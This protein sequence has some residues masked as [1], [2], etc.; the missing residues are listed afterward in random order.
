MYIYYSRGTQ[1]SQLFQLQLHNEVTRE[2]ATGKQLLQYT[3]KYVEG[4]RFS[5]G[6]ID[7]S[8]KIIES[9]VHNGTIVLS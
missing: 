6:D 2:A 4:S 3:V 1:V 8:K 5:F 9:Q 7:R